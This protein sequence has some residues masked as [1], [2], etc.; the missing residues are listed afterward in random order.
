MIKQY[1]FLCMSNTGNV[2]VHNEDNFSFFGKYMPREHQSLEGM[3]E[4]SSA[5]DSGTAVAIFDGMGGESAGELASFTAAKYFTD[6][7]SLALKEGAEPGDM[8]LELNR[9]VLRARDEEKYSSIGATA[10]ILKTSPTVVTLASIGDSRAYLIRGGGMKLLNRLHTD[11]A[12]IERLGISRKPRITQCLGTDESEVTLQPSLVHGW[13]EEGDVFLICTDGLTDMVGEE[14]IAGIIFQSRTF[15]EA[16]DALMR[17]ALENGG[18]DNITFI[19]C[20]AE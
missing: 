13:A 8:I 5:A 19:L 11:E 15:G 20:R 17:E 12:M 7:G 9:E 1:H 14:D 16:A 2:R 6:T 3:L 10:V 18:K 4:D